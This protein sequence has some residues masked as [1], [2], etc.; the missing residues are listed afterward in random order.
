[1]ANLNIP[2]GP[3]LEEGLGHVNWNREMVPPAQFFQNVN[4]IQSIRAYC[5]ALD[6]LQTRRT[7]HIGPAVFSCLLRVLWQRMP[8]VVQDKSVLGLG[9]EKCIGTSDF[10]GAFPGNDSIFSCS[11][12]VF[13]KRVGTAAMPEPEMMDKEYVIWSVNVGESVLRPP[14]GMDPFAEPEPP[15]TLQHYVTIVMHLEPSD[16]VNKPDIRDRITHLAIAD[17]MHQ[18]H[19]SPEAARRFKDGI[20]DR[21]RRFLPKYTFAPNF[22]RELWT[23]PLDQDLVNENFATPFMACSVTAQLY[24]RIAEMEFSNAGFNPDAFFRPTRPFFNP[25]TVRSELWGLL[26]AKL[27]ALLDWKVRIG[28][29]PTNY[30]VDPQLGGASMIQS[31]KFDETLPTVH[32]WKDTSTAPPAGGA[33]ADDGQVDDLFGD[34]GPVE[35]MDVDDDAAPGKKEMGTQAGGANPTEAGTQTHAGA[36]TSQGTQ[37][38]SSSQTTQ[39]GT[40]TKDNAAG[41][42]SKKNKKD[43]NCCKEVLDAERERMLRV[44]IQRKRAELKHA[45]TILPGYVAARVGEAETMSRDMEARREHVIAEDLDEEEYDDGQLADLHV[46]VEHA[47]LGLRDA[48]NAVRLAGTVHG[49][50]DLHDDAARALLLGARTDDLYGERDALRARLARV[51]AALVRYERVAAAQ[52]ALLAGAETAALAAEDR[53]RAEE[54][55]ARKE[56]AAKESKKRKKTQPKAKGKAE[57]EAKGKGKAEAEAKGKGKAQVKA[58]GKGEEKN[59]YYPEGWFDSSSESESDYSSSEEESVNGPPPSDYDPWASDDGAKK[60]GKGKKKVKDVPVPKWH[61]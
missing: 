5:T 48:E 61:S 47:E 16:P 40:Q 43:C 24:D 44:Y 14:F 10:T 18:Q 51:R 12:E 50:V 42:S 53:R 4:D 22:E 34:G 41:P 27:M 9:T 17:P 29:V 31:L 7:F 52:G 45:Q 1:M 60:K 25:D 57:A 58:K 26:C 55:R 3:I 59:K 56:K 21:L 33:G 54:E 38:G 8:Q 2:N 49:D 46:A 23:P 19:G 39:R 15:Q 32:N 6:S 37:A 30:T 13:E 28:L 20:I 11:D 36:T 35:G